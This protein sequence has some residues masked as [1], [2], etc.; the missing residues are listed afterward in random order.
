MSC[1]NLTHFHSLC[2]QVNTQ[3]IPHLFTAYLFYVLLTGTAPQGWCYSQPCCVRSLTFYST[4]IP[5]WS[6]SIPSFLVANPLSIVWAHSLQLVAYLWD[7][8]LSVASICCYLSSMQYFQITQDGCDP[9]LS[10]LVWLHYALH[11]ISRAQLRG[12]HLT[13]LPITIKVLLQNL[14]QAWGHSYP[15]T[16][17]VCSGLHVLC[18][19]FHFW[20]RKC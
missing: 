2:P 4:C 14:F 20:T 8:Q 11:G 12:G 17:P 10:T 18:F 19:F 5:L 7:Q 16:T 3:I 13:C 9:S 15:N 1:G 6:P